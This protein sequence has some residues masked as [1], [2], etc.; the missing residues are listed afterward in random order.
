MSCPPW[1]ATSTFVVGAHLVPCVI[2][3]RVVQAAGD[4][5]LALEPSCGM[6]C[7]VSNVQ[8]RAPS[9][10]ARCSRG[11]QAVVPSAWT[12]M[13]LTELKASGKLLR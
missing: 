5:G 9:P 7:L 1:H 2:H 10:Y 3:L 12:L 13:K 8:H 4:G 11:L 6:L